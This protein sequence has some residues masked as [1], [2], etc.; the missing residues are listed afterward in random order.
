[1]DACTDE[2]EQDERQCVGTSAYALCRVGETDDCLHFGEAQAC[3]EG[4][5]CSAGSCVAPDVVEEMPDATGYDA[6]QEE[7]VQTDVGQE[8]IVS[9]DPGTPM[10]D[11]VT[12]TDTMLDTGTLEVQDNAG[13]SPMFTPRT[14]DGCSGSGHAKDGWMAVLLL[15]SIVFMLMRSQRMKPTRKHS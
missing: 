14:G 15:G 2:C 5:T 10:M 4:L 1:V 7:V 13:E 6:A 11:G 8:T 3:S 9:F 12:T